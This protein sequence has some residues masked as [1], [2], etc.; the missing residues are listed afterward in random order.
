MGSL[1]ALNDKLKNTHMLLTSSNLAEI[2]VYD[3][4]KSR[5]NA[6]LESIL[7]INSMSMFKSMLELVNVQ[8]NLADNWLFIVDYSKVKSL[9]KKN[10]GIFQ[11][12]TSV[13]LIKVNSYKEFKEVKELEMP[14]NDLYLESIRK[15]EVYDLLRGYNISQKVKDF[16][17]SSY[18]K[19][20][21]KVFVFLNEVKNG[22][23]VETTKDVVKIC[24]ESS[25]SIQ[26]FVL[27]L[28]TDS[29]NTDRFL[30]R[31][32][33]KRV[34]SLCDLCDAFGT[35]TA[36]NFIRAT[37]KDIM[38]IKI[39]YL[40]GVI[41]DRVV[42]IP[43]CFDEKKLMRYNYCI[44]VITGGISYSRILFLYQMLEQYG[45]WKTSQDGI[46]FLYKYYIDLI[47]DKNVNNGNG[48]YIN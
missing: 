7:D 1:K 45:K 4:L 9:I 44:K 2:Y 16:V 28:L 48:N 33:K 21:D 6:T 19:D 8:P 23:V 37:I 5:C 38:S 47:E 3:T 24:G 42:N 20:P 26:K 46:L 17:A 31:S 25:G 13:F 43:D 39:L 18:F 15:V 35:R 10:M 27:Q 32:Y 11:A 29:P 41:Y 40:N 30:Y 36:N 14:V 34:N 12:K 22:A